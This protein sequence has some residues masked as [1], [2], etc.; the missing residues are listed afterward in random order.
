MENLMRR[1]VRSLSD[2]DNQGGHFI[3]SGDKRRPLPSIFT[4]FDHLQN[5]DGF[6]KH[7]RPRGPRSLVDEAFYHLLHLRTDAH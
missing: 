2:S 3:V 5:G 7:I 6:T 4:V 1:Q